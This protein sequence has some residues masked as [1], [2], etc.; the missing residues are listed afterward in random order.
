MSDRRQSP[1]LGAAFCFSLA[2]AFACSCAPTR[3]GSIFDDDWVAPAQPGTNH[4]VPDTP[5]T[6]PDVSQPSAPTTRPAAEPGPPAPA[7]YTSPTPSEDLASRLEVPA[8]QDLARSRKVMKEVYAAEL[9]D[10][11][12]QGR[13]A[14]SEKLLTEA[15]KLDSNPVDEFVVLGGA[16]TAAKEGGDLRACFM[17]ADALAAVFQLDAF[18][19]KVD[20]V[21]KMSPKV[22]AANLGVN[23][24]AAMEVV[25][26]L[27]SA[28]DFAAAARLGSLLQPITAGDANLHRLVQ[29]RRNEIDAMR[30]ARDRLRPQL[31]KL[32]S[33]PGDPPANLAVGTYVCFGRGDWERGLTM[34]SKSQDAAL[35]RLARQDLSTKGNSQSLFETASAWWKYAETLSGRSQRVVRG[36]A[37]DQYRGALRFLDGLQKLAAERRIQ[38]ADSPVN[39][40][41]SIQSKSYP[42]DL[43]SL[44]DPVRDRIVGDWRLEKGVLYSPAVRAEIEIPY[45][46]PAEY[47]FAIEF[48]RI[49]GNDTILQHLTTKRSMFAW[50]LGGYG[51]GICGFDCVG[52]S[53]VNAN[54]TTVNL[55]FT[56]HERHRST[57]QVRRGHVAG[58]L[59][60]N[61]LRDYKTD[62]SDLSP[63]PDWPF[64]EHV[65]GIG[66]TECSCAIYTAE[67]LEVSGAGHRNITPVGLYDG[68][69]PNWQSPLRLFPDGHFARGPT[70][71]EDG[72]AWDFD[73]TTLN[74]KWANWPPNKLIPDN[75]GGFMDT[76]GFR[77]HPH[78]QP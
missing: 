18:P 30:A 17:A 5:P 46:P 23:V 54:P 68:N 47:D 32:K 45:T 43:L 25:D 55:G 50:V 49:D 3:A 4:S 58:Y 61:L 64:R 31:E 15:A 77:L 66:T 40:F 53:R 8:E 28:E 57:V 75:E 9:G 34:L 59:D 78:K 62:Y 51:N 22:F 26:R 39:A 74:L 76:Q 44:I 60:G 27:A 33:A 24:A 1:N 69:H 37:A 2:F 16:I 6:P 10:H 52:G 48:E 67:L 12:V 73:G 13:C 42:I 56:N 71:S 72:G 36:H 7:I 14:L 11:T 29:Q 20:A 21:M 63:A 35:Q 70:T 65:L 19:V 38:E 41:A